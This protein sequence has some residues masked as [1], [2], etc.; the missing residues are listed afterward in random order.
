MMSTLVECIRGKAETSVGG[1]TYQFERDKHGRFVTEVHDPNH[2]KC[3][4]SVEHYRIAPEVVAEPE[5]VEKDAQSGD[6]DKKNQTTSNDASTSPGAQTGTKDPAPGKTAPA[7]PRSTGRRRKTT[8]AAAST[9]ASAPTTA[10][11]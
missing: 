10:A 11:S 6:P 2:V 3:L 1:L 8:K 9:G 5:P 7:K 4:L